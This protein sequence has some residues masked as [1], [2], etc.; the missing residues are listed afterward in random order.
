MTKCRFCLRKKKH[1]LF[2]YLLTDS[3][4]IN[5]WD[6]HSVA[7]YI[8]LSRLPLLRLHQQ[9]RKLGYRVGVKS[10]KCASGY[11]ILE[12]VI[13]PIYKNAYKMKMEWR[14]KARKILNR[15][16]YGYIL[17]NKYN[18][19]N[20]YCRDIHLV[21]NLTKGIILPSSRKGIAKNRLLKH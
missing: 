12:L 20:I 6:K 5:Q 19:K 9:N 16:K 11:W 15:I 3:R 1:P 17:A 18:I 8:G 4:C 13:G 7:G 2:L 21:H 10:T 14:E